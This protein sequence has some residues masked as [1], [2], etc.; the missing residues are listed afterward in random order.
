MADDE[1]SPTAGNGVPAPDKHRGLA[2]AWKPGQSGNPSGR[3][4]GS[5]NKLGE[6]FLQAL[7]TDF[8]EHGAAAIETV[9]KDKPD[10]YLKVIASVLPAHINVN[11]NRDLTDEELDRRIR[12][13]AAAL[14]IGLRIEGPSGRE[15]AESRH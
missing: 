1:S 6:E 3:A 5:R 14:D 8:T 12:D 11:L 4:R 13:L 10:A 7:Y 2:P 15:E 9:R